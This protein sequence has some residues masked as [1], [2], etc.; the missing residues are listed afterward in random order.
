MIQD[1]YWQRVTLLGKVLE[2]VSQVCTKRE[3]KRLNT[4]SLKAILQQRSLQ[5]ANIKREKA[6]K[7]L[8][9][10]PAF[11][12]SHQSSSREGRAEETVL[13]TQSLPLAPDVRESGPP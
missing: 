1:A 13:G 7:G 10:T 9:T 2:L 6:D 12:C 5:K 4:S 3:Q 8:K 11:L